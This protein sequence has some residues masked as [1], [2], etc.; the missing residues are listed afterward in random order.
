MVMSEASANVKSQG[1]DG[2]GDAW[3]TALAT[4]TAEICKCVH[5]QASAGR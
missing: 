1:L 3:L 4:G 5:P 2:A